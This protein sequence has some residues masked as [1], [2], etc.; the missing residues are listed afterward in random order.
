MNLSS[1]ILTDI[2]SPP[3]RLCLK[4]GVRFQELLVAV[5]S[6]L[7][8]EARSLL[9]R[10][11][12]P[13]N[14][15]KISVMTGLQRPDV[16]KH[17]DVRSITPKPSAVSQVISTW[18]YGK[19]FT[20]K[21][22]KPRVLSASGKDSE[23]SRLVAAVSKELSPYTVLFEMERAGLIEHTDDGVRLVTSV[24]FVSNDL[25]KGLEILGEDLSDLTDAVCQNL[26][27]S[28]PKNLHIRIDY[29]NIPTESLSSLKTEM[30][31]KVQKCLIEVQELIRHYDRD[32]S[33]G[34]Q[35]IL[36]DPTTRSRI[37]LTVFSFDEVIED[38]PE[39]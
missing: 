29:D 35:E 6:S 30:F 11:G 37:S 33:Q 36:K 16:S 15:T 18:M 20:N 21:Q 3:I 14:P 38:P 2:F 12:I 34:A 13:H 24:Q 25:E 10:E 32:T 17:S 26:T 1:R 8:M 9:T 23:F 19:R 39:G 27:S 31:R 28:P 4:N 5:K 7:V 22:G